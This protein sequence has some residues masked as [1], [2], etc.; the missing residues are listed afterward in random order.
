MTK[1]ELQ[2]VLDWTYDK[3]ATGAE[4]RGLGIST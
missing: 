3:L 1:A 2:K 4:P